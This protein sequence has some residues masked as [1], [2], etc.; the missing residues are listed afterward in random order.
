MLWLSGRI[1]LGRESGAVSLSE[2]R[3]VWIMKMG[4]ETWV[5]PPCF[6]AMRPSDAHT[7]Q[8]SKYSSIRKPQICIDD[9]WKR[10]F[11]RK[12]RK[13]FTGK[14]GIVSA[15][16][17]NG[18]YR[19]TYGYH[20]IVGY[21]R[22]IEN[23]DEL[24]LHCDWKVEEKIDIIF[25]CTN[26]KTW[27]WV[28]QGPPGAVTKMISLNTVQKHWVYNV[29]PPSLHAKKNQPLVSMPDH[30]CVSTFKFSPKHQKTTVQSVP[31]WIWIEHSPKQ[32]IYYARKPVL[33]IPLH[34]ELF[35]VTLVSRDLHVPR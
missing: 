24:S 10:G 31:T 17:N 25:A 14:E 26:S 6:V 30:R 11:G 13:H 35:R 20:L 28:K 23:R 18:Q 7:N 1:L 4:V 22:R 16:R 5:T 19:K 32:P 3:R 15:S 29:I 21:Q 9:S 2:R 27:S 12:G 34:L 8:T 33:S